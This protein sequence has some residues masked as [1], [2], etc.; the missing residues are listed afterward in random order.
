MSEI[1]KLKKEVRELIR[2]YFLLTSKHSP[3][4]GAYFCPLKRNWYIK[5]QMQVAHYIDRNRICT[6]YEEDNLLLV[7]K[8]SNI[9]DAQIPHKGFKSKHHYDF[10][11]YLGPKKVEELEKRSRGNCKLTENFLSSYIDYYRKKIKD[12]E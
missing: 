1:K 12:W 11:R 8:A 7:S 4:I 3:S 10:A 6:T 2:E 5:D 9:W